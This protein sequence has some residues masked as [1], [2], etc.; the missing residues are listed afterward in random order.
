MFFNY[1]YARHLFY[2]DST[3]LLSMKSM[4]STVQTT[5]RILRNYIRQTK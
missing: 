4:N 2:I 1:L 3:R 5:S